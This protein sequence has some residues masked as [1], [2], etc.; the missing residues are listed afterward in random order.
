MAD[1]KL[2]TS[3]SLLR[4]WR[5]SQ[6]HVLQ[7]STVLRLPSRHCWPLVGVLIEGFLTSLTSLHWV[8]L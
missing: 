3:Q 1:P 7:A 8:N 4:R 5:R 6:A 2:S